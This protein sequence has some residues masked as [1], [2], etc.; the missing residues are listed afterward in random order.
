M[1]R[2]TV[3]D[4]R[5]RTDTIDLMGPRARQVAL[6]VLIA[7]GVIARVQPMLFRRTPFVSLEYDDGVHFFAAELL[8]VGRIPYD[9]FVFVQPP[10]VIILLLPFAGLAHIVGDSVGFVLARIAFVGV[11]VANMLLLYRI[12]SRIRPEVGVIA[13]AFYSV[14]PRAVQTEQ[15]LYLEQLLNLSLLLAVDLLERQDRR[16]SGRR[17]MLAGLILGLGVSI[18]LVGAVALGVIALRVLLVQ[19]HAWDLG[20]LVAGAAIGFMLVC[21][22]WLILAPNEMVRQTLVDQ[23][24]RP[25]AGIPVSTRL[26]SIVMPVKASAPWPAAQ[27]ALWALACII[28]GVII[29]LAWRVPSARFWSALLLAQTVV[30]FQSPSFYGHYGDYLLPAASLLLGTAVVQARLGAGSTAFLPSR[31]VWLG[32]IGCGLALAALSVRPSRGIAVDQSRLERFALTHQCVYARSPD[33]LIFSDAAIRAAQ[34]RCHMAVDEYGEA[35]DEVHGTSRRGDVLTY[36]PELSTWQ[37]RVR[38]RLQAADAAL[39]GSSREGWDETTK[40]FFDQQ[41]RLA[42]ETKGVY[43]WVQR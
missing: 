10:G 8:T 32:L 22:P 20:R 25:A 3:P 9:D 28:G 36:L 26:W 12:G 5:R 14:W 29:L 18:K 35:L 39:L 2:G 41:F 27:L 31:A 43:L 38:N 42:G 17:L 11:Y 19:R 13:V 16:W 23:I 33:L 24:E 21:G 40:S 37:L 7:V 4:G 30:L 1:V 6:V 15:T 34:D